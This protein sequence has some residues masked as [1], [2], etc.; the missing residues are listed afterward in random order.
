MIEAWLKSAPR[1]TT[2][3]AGV[4]AAALAMSFAGVPDLPADPAW[5]AVILCGVPILYV[6]GRGIMDGFDIRAGVLVSL[7][8][9][10]ALL[11]KEYFAAGEVALIMQI[12]TLLEDWTVARARAGLEG[13]A[14]LAPQ[15]AHRLRGDVQETVPAAEVRAGDLLVVR[16]GE[17]VPVDGTVTAGESAVDAAVMTGE[18]LPVDKRAGDAVISGTVNTYGTFTMRA[19]K[20]ATDS[21]LQRMIALAREADA[22]KAP[23]VRLADRWASWLVGIALA[24][25]LL[26]WWGTGE[27]VRGVTV[28]VVF[29]PCAFVLATP[30]AVAA[31]IGNLTRHGVLIRT[32]DALER[33]ARVQTVAFDKTGTLTHGT[34]RVVAVRALS[35]AY[36]DEEVLRLA[37]AA[38][39][40]S[41]HPLGRA[42]VAAYLEHG[43]PLPSARDTQV[44][45]GRG[46]T[47]EVER[48]KITVGSPALLAEYA[49]ADTAEQRAAAYARDGA[50]VSCVAVDDEII[51]IVALADTLRAEAAAVVAALHARGIDTVLLTGDSAA[52]AEHI[53]A[54]AGIAELRSALLPADKMNYV[55]DERRRIAMVGDGINDALALKAAYVGVAVGGVGSD[56]AAASADAVLVAGGVRRLPHLFAMAER[57]M[58]KVRQNIFLGLCI[59]FVA[60]ALS[61]L[62]LL[63]PVTG[64]LWHNAGSVL[65]VVNAA[66]LLRARDD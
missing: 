4:S 62:G 7:A 63:T 35:G 55:A 11:T 9:I 33:L 38:E 3:C 58:R 24:C 27:L 17:T 42:V 26:V 21:S 44:R 14:A 28:L 5:I 1:P 37:A 22:K 31:S 36:T 16:A 47:A 30:T 12:G 6:A 45:A 57:C 13:L 23:I 52:A 20:A 48:R 61:A 34:P 18:S 46:I 56:I 41:E 32:G 40:H 43:M 59:N 66:L 8:L 29:C 65:V 64:A 60:V 54:Q 2:F 50:T 15:A 19:E 53:G 49:A 39:Q 25:A 10:A 51:G